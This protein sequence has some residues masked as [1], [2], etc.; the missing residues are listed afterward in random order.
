VSDGNGMVSMRRRAQKLGGELE[1]ISR[2]G[3]GT[4]VILKAPLGGYRG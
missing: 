4:I 2:P 1:V 3:E